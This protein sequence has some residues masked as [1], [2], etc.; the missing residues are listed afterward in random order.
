VDQALGLPLPVFEPS[1]RLFEPCFVVVPVAVGLVEDLGGKAEPPRDREPIAAAGASFSNRYVGSI[2]S[3]SNC[4]DAFTIPV[5]SPSSRFSAPRC[6]DAMVSAPRA[7][8]A[9]STARASAA[10]SAGS[11]PVPISSTSTRERVSALATISDRLARCAEKV[12]RLCAID[13]S[14]P[15]SA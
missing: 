14:S 3:A 2:R 6:D 7:T 11:V 1:E 10:P 15:M 9:S 12:D 8:N 4:R 13:C 5:P